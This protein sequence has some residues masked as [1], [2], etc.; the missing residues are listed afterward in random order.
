M[1]AK[2]HCPLGEIMSR[3]IAALGF[4]VA[5][6]CWLLP[7]RVVHAAPCPNLAIIVDRSGSMLDNVA[8]Q[9]PMAGE[10]SRWQI[11]KNAITT[12]VTQYD[13]KL[14]I[15]ISYFPRASSSCGTSGFAVNPGYGTKQAILQSLDNP[16]VTPVTT[17]LTPTC[18]AIDAVA[19]DAAMKDASRGQYILLVTDGAPRCQNTVGCTCDACNSLGAVYAAIESVRLANMQSP[20][21]HTFVVGFGGSLGTT[22]KQNLN[23]MAKEGGEAN[24]DPSYDYYPAETEAALATQLDRIIRSITGGGDAGPG[25][26]LCDDSCYTNGC[27]AGKVCVQ[28]ACQANPCDGKTCGAGEY[29]YSDGSTATCVATCSTS[30]GAGSRCIRGECVADPCGTP[31]A[32][33][34]KCDPATKQCQIDQACSSVTCKSAQSCQAG[35]C[36]DDPCLYTSCPQGF[37]CVQFE[38]T[39]LPTSDGSI[40]RGCSCELQANHNHSQW[41]ALAAPLLLWAMLLR[42]RRRSAG[43]AGI[44]S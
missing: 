11:A 1:R 25:S 21:I 20:S 28:A 35:K 2:V 14:P 18:G 3:L 42:R 33:G 34:R 12:L 38:G 4:A 40:A 10:L 23:D 5:S 27:P 44:L 30:C 32:S 19:A 13:G 31:C 9:P 7:L 24:P 15:G 36:I 39:C 22:E 17:A 8:G 41:A 6:L 26:V 37:A 29:C 43:S 16:Q